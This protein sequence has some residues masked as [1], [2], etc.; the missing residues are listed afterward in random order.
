MFDGKIT[1]STATIR[2]SNVIVIVSL[3]AIYLGEEVVLRLRGKKDKISPD[4]IQNNLYKGGLVNDLQSALS[5]DRLNML[6]WGGAI[7]SI[8]SFAYLILGDG[9]SLDDK[10]GTGRLELRSSTLHSMSLSAAR[11]VFIVNM[12]VIYISV[13]WKKNWVIAGTMIML[14]V[15][16]GLV[17][18]ER[19]YLLYA[20]SPLL[21]IYLARGKKRIRGL[22]FAG[23]ILGVFSV[24][25]FGVLHMFRWQNI[26]NEEA[27]VN[28]LFD[29][30]TYEFMLTDDQSDLNIRSALFDAVDVF[31]EKHDWLYGNTYKTLLLFW[32]PSSLSSGYKVD[33][34]Y[35]FAYAVTGDPDTVANRGSMHPTLV[36]DFYINLGYFYCVGAFLWGVISGT[37]FRTSKEDKPSYVNLIVGSC[38]IYFLMVSLRGSI[39]QAFLT[40]VW[41][42]FWLYIINW[43]IK[44]ISLQRG[45]QM[46]T[47][48]S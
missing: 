31:P 44:L 23:I 12:V 30:Y 19:A 6:M 4:Y 17:F 18:G 16:A 42:S 37:I 24:F 11:W 38:W 2:F 8:L 27:L 21:F 33:T 20:V 10:L 28:V 45:Q 34:M 14:D 1:Y 26:R 9:L 43:L 25:V 36:G 22:I 40:I 7:V 5:E 46:V 29:P 13:Y 39:H 32:L 48:S 47:A 15:L 35:L 3:F 41:C